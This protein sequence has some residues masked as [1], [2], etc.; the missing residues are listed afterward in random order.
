MRLTRV[1]ILLVAI[2]VAAGSL[3]AAPAHA[4]YCGSIGGIDPCAAACR[5]G[6]AA[7][8]RCVFGP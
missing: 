2:L 1:R 5:V 8:L 7:H 3:L 6:Y 4:V